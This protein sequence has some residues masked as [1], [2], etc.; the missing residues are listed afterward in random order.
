MNPGTFP[1]P[2][3]AST[4]GALKHSTQPRLAVDTHTHTHTHTHRLRE[5]DQEY[6]PTE[7][8]RPAGTGQNTPSGHKHTKNMVG[9]EA[10][11]LEKKKARTRAR[12]GPTQPRPTNASTKTTSE[13]SQCSI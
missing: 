9:I 13:A 1:V 5:G 4:S 10:R 12:H 7:D 3:R 8:H 2:Q 11:C 6:Q